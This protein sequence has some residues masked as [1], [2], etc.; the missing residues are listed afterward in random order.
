MACDSFSQSPQ[1]GR[2]AGKERR[3][4]EMSWVQAVVGL[5]G[6]SGKNRLN[7]TS[8]ELGDVGVRAG[9]GW[10]LPAAAG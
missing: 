4:W 5:G 1:E 7:S 8:L 10:A 6:S 2:F 3:V 9:P